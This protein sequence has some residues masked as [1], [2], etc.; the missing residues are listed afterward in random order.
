MVQMI[1]KWLAALLTGAALAALAYIGHESGKGPDVD[2][3]V[4]LV[5][6][7]LVTKLVTWLTGKLPV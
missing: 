7:T 1:L 5:V 3:A 4:A 2:P 6:T